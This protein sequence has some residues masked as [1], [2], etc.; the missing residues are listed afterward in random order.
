MKMKEK[1]VRWAN[2]TLKK[3]NASKEA[4]LTSANVILTID[5][6]KRLSEAVSAA[7][8][9]GYDQCMRLNDKLSWILK[10]LQ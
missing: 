2:D 9:L 4:K 1:L 5:I 7:E 8:D 3:S 10:E 6:A